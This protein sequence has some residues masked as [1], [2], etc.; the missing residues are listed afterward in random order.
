MVGLS[1]ECALWVLAMVFLALGECAPV[2]W[3]LALGVFVLL[4]VAV[5]VSLVLGVVC[6]SSVL[7]VCVFLAKVCAPWIAGI[8]HPLVG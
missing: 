3:D 6:V 4:V 8:S 7:A 5:C 2:A 1:E